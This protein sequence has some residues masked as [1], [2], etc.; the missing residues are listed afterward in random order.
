MF[1]E[2]M[3]TKSVRRLAYFLAGAIVTIPVMVVAQPPWTG[4]AA[5]SKISSS[6][7]KAHLDYINDRSPS[8]V[9][10]STTGVATGASATAFSEWCPAGTLAFPHSCTDTV[11]AVAQ[12]NYFGVAADGPGG[13]ERVLCNMQN[14]S[15]APTN[16]RAVARCVRLR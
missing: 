9:D 11:N 12:V 16:F 2:K 3:A 13:R 14:L 4:I 1:D 5:N 8:T 6:Q 7:L 10:G 15:A